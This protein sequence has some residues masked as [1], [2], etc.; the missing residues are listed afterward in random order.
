MK[1]QR[2]KKL[3]RWVVRIFVA[4]PLLVALFILEENL[5]GRILLAHYKAELRSKGEKLTLAELGVVAESFGNESGRELLETERRLQQL[6]REC[7]FPIYFATYPHF[8]EPGRSVVFSRESRLRAGS[9]KLTPPDKAQQYT[10]GIGYRHAEWSDLVMQVARASN[11]LT[12]LKTILAHDDA[13][14]PVDLMHPLPEPIRRRPD[15]IDWLGVGGLQALRQHDLDAVIRN[16]GAITALLKVQEQVRLPQR[17]HNCSD[18]QDVASFLTW[19]VLQET[20]SDDQL[21]QL[22]RV[23]SVTNSIEEALLVGDIGR[24]RQLAEYQ[25]TIRSPRKWW[26]LVRSTMR[27]RVEPPNPEPAPILEILS[28]NLKALARGVA[29]LCWNWTGDELRFLQRWQ[30]WLPA[31][32][33]ALRRRNLAYLQGHVDLISVD[34][35]ERDLLGRAMY[36]E[37]NSFEAIRFETRREMAL[38]AIA[39][40]RFVVR[41][42]HPPEELRELCPQFLLQLPHD[43]FG[44][45]PLR[46]R[47][48][49]DSFRLYSVGTDRNDDGGN[50]GFPGE[51]ASFWTGKDI[52]WPQP[53]SER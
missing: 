17:Q 41:S 51:R 7:P 26:Q 4:L 30:S 14:L 5:R 43:W 3:L 24:I 9:V 53:V 10:Q 44:G 16:V 38:T 6:G 18:A 48:N 37:F 23:W 40:Q 27:S 19:H 32:R 22:Q 42:G 31:N 45:Q 13:L 28:F 34:D 29:W 50:A 39:I 2:L 52:V 20:L 36:S 33:E 35:Y 8:V 15:S 25:E 21:T 12:R 47:R 46:Y 49:G 1:S 11:D